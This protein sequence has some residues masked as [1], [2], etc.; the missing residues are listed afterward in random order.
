MSRQGGA[1]V[2]S[3]VL[4]CIYIKMDYSLIFSRY[5]GMAYKAASQHTIYKSDTRPRPAYNDS[6]KAQSMDGRQTNQRFDYV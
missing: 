3:R 1:S 4:H 5:D 6:Y 2:L